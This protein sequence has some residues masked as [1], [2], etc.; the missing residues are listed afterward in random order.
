MKKIIRI[1]LLTLV[2]GA[3]FGGNLFSKTAATASSTPSSV[4]GGGGPMPTCNP[5]TQSCPTIR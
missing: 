4:P 5:F 1:S 3:A 2:I